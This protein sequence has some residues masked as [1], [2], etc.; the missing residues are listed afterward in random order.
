MNRN[1]VAALLVVAGLS[2]CGA[3]RQTR[4]EQPVSGHATP[5]TADAYTGLRRRIGVVDFENK[6][7][8]GQ[9]RMGG[10]AADVLLT[11]LAKTR[12]FVVV[13]RE[14][15]AKLMQE[16]KLGTTGMI[17]AD[18]AAQMGKV[19]GLNAIVTGSVSNFGISTHASDFVLGQRKAQKAEVT[20]DVR[21]VDAETGKVLHADSG[22]GSAQLKTG[23]ILGFG[24]K[25]GYEET[26]EGD[27]LRAAL[28]QLAVNIAAQINE[29]EWSCRVAD[30]QGE[31]IYLDAGKESGLKV[32]S[33]LL[34]YRLGRE[35]KSPATGAVIGRVQEKL[36][37]AEV[38]EFF[39][40]NGSIAKMAR[41]A[42]PRA[43]DLAKPAPEPK[44]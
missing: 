36:G 35:I 31:Q 37:E 32:G 10:A 1:F 39:G 29:A 41:G 8:Y 9:G 3:S 2:G 33:R 20:V 25:A 21:V 24:S 6:S 22:K 19:L 42:G 43:G 38:V 7:A 13:E 17:D 4:M 5:K 14:K 23:E 11:E 40:D 44:R 28:S 12:K 26:L 15:L 30:T 16:Q 18:T 27:A 34:I